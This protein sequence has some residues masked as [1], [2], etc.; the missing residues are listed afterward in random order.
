MVANTPTA[1]DGLASDLP[2][3]NNGYVLVIGGANVDISG[4]A[5]GP[6]ILGDSHPGSVRCTPGGVAR[7]IAENLARLGHATRLV[8]AL[9]DDL[10][11]RGL[12]E[13]AQSAGVNT[14]HCWTDFGQSTSTYLSVHAGDGALCVGVNDMG[15]VNSI[16]PARLADQA[17][18]IQQAHTVVL[19][20]N[21]SADTI[22]WVLRN[23]N[24]PVLVDAVSAK[25][26]TRL[27]PLLERIHTLKLNPLEAQALCGLPCESAAQLLAVARWLHSQGVRQVLLSLGARGMF[28]SDKDAGNGWQDAL[29]GT[30]V[31]V[32]GGGD[33]LLSGWAHAL[34]H[35]QP[36]AQAAKWAQACAGMTVG[37]HAANH[38]HLSAAALAQWCKTLSAPV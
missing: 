14:D 2:A 18:L 20:C 3:V 13:S 6:L 34:L 21:L 26:C 12:L 24:A 7:N 29:T 5:A 37:V 10:F 8:A 38:P 36:L 11:G 31:N 27:Q 25:K 28:W 19:D 16:T 4:T 1:S 23:T 33:A 30:V 15:I 32:T 17:P 9:G 35:R 22:G